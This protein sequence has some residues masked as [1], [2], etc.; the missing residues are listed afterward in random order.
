MPIHPIRKHLVQILMVGVRIQVSKESGQR[1]APLLTIRSQHTI[2]HHR[3]RKFLGIGFRP[4]SFTPT[5]L[6]L[7]CKHLCDSGLVLGLHSSPS[8]V[9]DRD[10]E[11]LPILSTSARPPHAKKFVQVVIKVGNTSTGRGRSRGTCLTADIL[12]HDVE[13]VKVPS[14]M[15]P[16]RDLCIQSFG[17]IASP[18]NRFRPSLKSL[19]FRVARHP[20]LQPRQSK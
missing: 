20:S 7:L 14:I 18:A 2:T 12:D 4:E 8:V 16:S 13:V 6:A 11:L 15:Q 9:M 19:N 5:I 10:A 1:P 3:A 17:F